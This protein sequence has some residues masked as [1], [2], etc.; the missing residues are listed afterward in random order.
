MVCPAWNCVKEGQFGAYELLSQSN[1]E[2]S[3]YM[4]NVRVRL[5]NLLRLKEIIAMNKIYLQTFT[6]DKIFFSVAAVFT[7]LCIHNLICFCF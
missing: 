2:H 3:W 6:L 1:A 5:A 4:K 7:L